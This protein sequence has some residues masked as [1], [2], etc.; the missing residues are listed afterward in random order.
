VLLLVDEL[1]VGEKHTKQQPVQHI[2]NWLA[3][4]LPPFAVLTVADFNCPAIL[5]KAE[6][7]VAEA[8]LFVFPSASS[9]R[10]CD[11]LG[12]ACPVSERGL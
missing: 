5:R 1:V 7:N 6:K 4:P 12:A 10:R 11:S 3:A 9:R 8:G 2:F